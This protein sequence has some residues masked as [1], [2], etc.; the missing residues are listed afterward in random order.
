MLHLQKNVS[1]RDLTITCGAI[2]DGNM[3][4]KRNMQRCELL[5][6]ICNHLIE[7][8]QSFQVE[9]VIHELAFSFCFYNACSSQ[10]GKMLT[11]NGLLHAHFNKQFCYSYLAPAINKLNHLLSQF[12]VDGPENETGFFNI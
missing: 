3:N 11:R 12:V 2:A 4:T 10:Y 7:Q 9:T 8:I 5:Q 6:Q 1:E